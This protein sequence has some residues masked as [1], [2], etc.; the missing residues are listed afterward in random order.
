VA[1]FNLVTPPTRWPR[2]YGLINSQT[3]VRERD[4]HW[5]VGLTVESDDCSYT[6]TNI[7]RDCRPAAAGGAATGQTVID[8]MQEGSGC[9]DYVDYVPFIIRVE[10]AC[11]LLLPAEIAKTEKTVIDALEALTPKA[12]EHE[13]YTG[14][15]AKMMHAPNMSLEGGATY[16]DGTVQAPVDGGTAADWDATLGLLEAAVARCSLGGPGVIHLN[17]VQASRL[18]ASGCC[19]FEFDKSANVIWTYSGNMIVIGAGY[20]LFAG[21]VSQPGPLTTPAVAAGAVTVNHSRD[22]LNHAF[23]TGPVQVRLTDIEVTSTFDRETNQHTIVAERFAAATWAPC[24]H[25]RVTT[26]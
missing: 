14:H 5:T 9:C 7:G 2:R 12:V 13:V 4:D 3:L 18:L 8:R 10:R 15:L 17:P 25:V 26:P 11:K 20:G 24:C 19:R 23:A 1:T 22:V 6:I 21:P 16:A